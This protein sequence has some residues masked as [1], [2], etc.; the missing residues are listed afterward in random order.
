MKHTVAS[1]TLVLALL[2]TVAA[3][4]APLILKDDLHTVSPLPSTEILRDPS[5]QLTLSDVRVSKKFFPAGLNTPSFGMTND[6]V[7]IR[8][9]L[10]NHTTQDSL[11]LELASPLM[12]SIKVYL[13]DDDTLLHKYETGYM[14]P[15]STRPVQHR[16]FVFPLTVPIQQ[17]IDVYMRIENQD[18]LEA[19]LQI[20]SRAGFYKKTHDE[21]YIFGAYLGIIIV[22]LIV[23]VIFFIFTGEEAY[24]DLSFFIVTYGFFQLTQNG[25]VYLYFFPEWLQG[26]Q[27]YI[28][29]S[30]SLVLLA[31]LQFSRE[32]LDLA[33]RHHVLNRLHG[34]IM[35][36]NA[37]IIPVAW[38]IPYPIAITV[39]ATLAIISSFLTLVAG[40]ILALKRYRPSYTFLSA[41][42]LLIVSS[43]I[44]AL[45]T[46]GFVPY[47]FFTNYVIQIGS[48]VAFFFFSVALADRYQYL[49]EK[50]KKATTEKIRIEEEGR[51]KNETLLRNF[52]LVLGSAIESR[53]NYTGGHV[54]RVAGY[55]MAMAEH[56]GFD[57][58]H[59]QGVY[60]G[61]IV[62]DLGKIGVPDHILNKRGKLTEEE[63]LEMEK[64]PDI[65]RKLLQQIEEIPM[66][67]NIAQ[68]HQEKWDGSGYPKGMKG[69][70][71][72]LEARIV[73]IADYWDAIITDRPYRDAMPLE[74]AF[75]VMKEERGRAFDP[76]LYDLFFDDEKMIYRVFLTPSQLKELESLVL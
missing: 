54:E 57:K 59:I 53:D 71:I 13:L 68:Y 3:G 12:D 35:I 49:R 63:R 74:K 42:A 36:L 26:F 55:S 15:L 18:R 37:V 75:R 62:H 24:R 38:I 40:V 9:S 76:E 6:A 46:L 17:K 32:F 10:I 21:Q 50:E 4:A 8:F 67:V 70:A 14:Q 44:Y 7:W 73:T 52:L 34:G 64:H 51:K 43:I 66:A 20:Y 1:I 16:N 61:S 60:L 30:I 22:M 33:R 65:G 23:H 2:H 29:L 19:P 11:Y 41:F 47:T 48:A 5:S 28:P 56:L 45:K 39:S 69:E 27:H 58:E 25:T 31:T 72:P